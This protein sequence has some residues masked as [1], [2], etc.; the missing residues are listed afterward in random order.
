MDLNTSNAKVDATT[1]TGKKPRVGK[2]GVELAYHHPDEYRKLT[3]EQKKELHEWR[4]K[5][6]DYKTTDKSNKSGNNSGK[7]N[8]GKRTYTERQVNALIKKQEKKSKKDSEKF[9]SLVAAVQ[10]RI[11]TPSSAKPNATVT[12]V[13]AASVPPGTNSETLKSIL[14]SAKN[15]VSN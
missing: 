15:T 6:R 7:K 3:D 8:K 14:C 1:T 9:D 5:N 4:S 2:T 11:A 13:S 10:D 12:Q